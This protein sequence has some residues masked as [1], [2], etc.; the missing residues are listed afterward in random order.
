MTS[1]KLCFWNNGL[2]GQ[3]FWTTCMRKVHIPKNGSS[4]HQTTETWAFEVQIAPH[5]TLLFGVGSFHLEPQPS[6]RV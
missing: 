6:K 3:L 4:V 2:I 5:Q 1:Q